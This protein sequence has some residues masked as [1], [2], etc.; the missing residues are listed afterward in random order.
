MNARRLSPLLLLLTPLC[1]AWNG[2]GEGTA[3]IR[4]I[5]R[6]A[7]AVS[8]GGAARIDVDFQTIL[9]GELPDGDVVLSLAVP[10]DFIGRTALLSD[11]RIWLAYREYDS[12]GRLVFE[13]T[14]PR[15]GRLE[16][17]RYGN[18]VD[19]RLW[20]TFADPHEPNIARFLDSVQVYFVGEETPPLARDTDRGGSTTVY[21]DSSQGCDDGFD[22]DPSP[23]ADDSGGCEGDDFES[24]DDS[25]SSGCEGDDW[26]DSSSGGSSDDSGGCEGD[27]V[28]G[29]S[30]SDWGGSDSSSSCEGDA[31]AAGPGRAV[32]RSPRIVKLINY[33][34]WLFVFLTLHLLR[35]RRRRFL[36]RASR[37]RGT[38]RPS[39]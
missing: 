18:T 14:K 27:D 4:G 38:T 1:V 29:G 30:D 17:Q 10:T 32:R 12:E 24:S 21:V 3:T 26:G 7:L 19:L 20:G 5:E 2:G 35:T 34:P 13:S 39:A 8:V 37:P 28:G 33:A 22:D 36:T 23:S 31:V 9:T 6:S 16:L 11:Q 25:A 15:D